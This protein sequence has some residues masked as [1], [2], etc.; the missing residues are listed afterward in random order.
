[1]MHDQ[2]RYCPKGPCF[3]GGTACGKIQMN[4][5]LLRD[6]EPVKA[7][8]IHFCR[9]TEHIEIRWYSVEIKKIIENY[10]GRKISHPCVV[11][12]FRELGYDCAIIVPTPGD[13][14]CAFNFEYQGT[15]GMLP[16]IRRGST[17]SGSWRTGTVSGG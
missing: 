10:L 8:I 15:A 12:A 2:G 4:E 16:S 5:C 11:A 6:I 9:K 14:L 7:W 3:L 17:T 1:M 13:P